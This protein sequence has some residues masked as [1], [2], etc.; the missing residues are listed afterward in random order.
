M[1]T[2]SGGLQNY[3]NCKTYENKDLRISLYFGKTDFTKDLPEN[4]LG[5]GKGYVPDIWAT[6]ETMKSVLQEM[7]VDTGDIIFQ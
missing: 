1:G 2:H 3:G 4:Y 5:D 6:T 7:G